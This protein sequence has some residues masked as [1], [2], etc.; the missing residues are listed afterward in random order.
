M[1]DIT[2]RYSMAYIITLTFIILTIAQLSIG[3]YIPSLPTIAVDLH[4]SVGQTQLCINVY[5]FFYGF[6][7]L[8]YGPLSD[9]YGRKPILLIGLVIFVFGTMGIVMVRNINMLLFTCFVQ[10]I[11]SGSISVLLRAIIRD[12]YDGKELNRSLSYVTMI[13]AI[14]PAIAP[15]IGG[16]IGSHFGWIWDFKSLTLYG[17]LVIL[18][19]IFA[20]PETNFKRHATLNLTQVKQDYF[21][22]LQHNHYMAYVAAII[23]IYICQIIMFTIAP[24]FFQ[25]HLG[26]TAQMF[27]IYAIVS[28]LGYF[29]GGLI[30]N[31]C[32]ERFSNLWFIQAALVIL[33]VMGS[34]LLLQAWF[35]GYNVASV[36]I[37]ILFI[38][39]GV[40]FVL[41]S[42]ISGALEPFPHIAGVAAA[43]TGCLQMVGSALIGAFIS[44]WHITT[45]EGMALGYLAVAAALY[46]CIKIL[47]GP[48]KQSLHV[49]S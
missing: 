41:A 37:P 40:G 49:S 34:L 20:L 30:Y 3:L 42:G 1:N 8:V 46:V 36:L 17:I 38:S 16:F 18:I 19:V 4:T 47:S 44:F 26:A 15:V 10:G 48:L 32:T 14:T 5:L 39:I 22:L 13:T 6:S 31:R 35:F 24:F 29:I 11:G 9:R 43:F 45:L 23:A 25:L 28:A 12:I 7:Q 2:L 21:E 27:G 33:I